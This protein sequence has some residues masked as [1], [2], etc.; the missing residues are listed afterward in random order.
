[1]AGIG[2]EQ[3]VEREFDRFIFFGIGI[4]AEEVVF[5]ADLVFADIV[6]QVEHNLVD[7][8]ALIY[9]AVDK[10]VAHLLVFRACGVE[11]L[12]VDIFKKIEPFVILVANRDSELA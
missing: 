11:N 2:A 1:M 5:S 7:E 9:I 10:E 3:I 6:P 12:R 4:V 8:L